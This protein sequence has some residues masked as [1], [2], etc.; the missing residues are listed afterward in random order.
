MTVRQHLIGAKPRTT[1]LYGLL[2]TG[3]SL[4]VGVSGRAPVSTTNVGGNQRLFDSSGV[5]DITLPNAGTLSLTNLVA[6]NRVDLYPGNASDDVSQYPNNVA[7]EDPDVA[8]ANTLW[9]LYGGSRVF[10]SSSVGQ[11][12]AGLAVIEKGGSG[13]AYAAGLYEMRAINRLHPGFQLFA[14]LYT[15]GEFDAAG[16]IATYAAFLTSQQADIQTDV[17]AITGQAGT[18]P[19]FVDQQNEFPS[20][21]GGV[22]NSCQAEANAPAANPGLI[23]ATCPKYW[24]FG[25]GYGQADRA[26]LTAN[27]YRVL[28][29][30][31]A[32]AIYQWM[33]NAKAIALIPTTV[34]RS[35][36]AVTV[37]YAP[38]VSPLVFDTTPGQPHASGTYSLWA[39]AKGFELW[40]GG[41]GGTP[42]AISSVAISGNTVVITGSSTPD[43]VAYAM[44]PD[45]VTGGTF[46]GGYPDGRCG[47]LRDSDTFATSGFVNASGVTLPN[48]AWAF[49]QGGL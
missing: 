23:I 28:G 38:F 7:G 22:N 49:V 4:S 43:T 5:Y 25:L 48:W 21:G 19:L 8:T 26:H 18:I 31:R 47:N 41:Y 12:G 42:V 3:Q 33:A 10:S 34:T 15:H 29:E 44:T 36:T 1:P 27:G 16:S 14:A 39:G 32:Q 11:G 2:Q 46:T 45:N 40:S 13:N 9:S 30:K 20:I 35:L 6:P 17:S 24:I 37:T